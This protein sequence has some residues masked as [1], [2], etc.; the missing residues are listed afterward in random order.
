MGKYNNNNNKNALVS[1]PN[2]TTKVKLTESV[3]ILPTYH[4]KMGVYKI[5]LI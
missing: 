3:S 4:L 1:I 5:H 2:T